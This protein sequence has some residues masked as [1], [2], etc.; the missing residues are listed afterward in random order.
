[1]NVDQVKERGFE[2]R[3]EGKNYNAV[4]EREGG[5]GWRRKGA[6]YERED[7]PSRTIEAAESARERVYSRPDE[8]AAGRYAE[9]VNRHIEKRAEY[10]QKRYPKPSQKHQLEH[11]QEPHIMAEHNGLE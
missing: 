11:V 5:Q 8:A 1:K 10:N 2:V 7:E 3:R 6:L 4:Q 9:R